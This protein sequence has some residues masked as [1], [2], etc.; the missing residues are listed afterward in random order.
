M[1]AYGLHFGMWRDEDYGPSSKYCDMKS[2]KRREWRRILHKEERNRIKKLI[3]RELN[4][5]L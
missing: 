3:R 4:E 1:K 5:E 2:K